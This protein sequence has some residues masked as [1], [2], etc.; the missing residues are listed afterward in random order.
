[1]KVTSVPVATDLVSGFEVIPGGPTV[2]KKRKFVNCTVLLCFCMFL[3][4]ERPLE[5]KLHCM[6]VSVQV[7]SDCEETIRHYTA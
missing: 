2:R 4:V 1:M 7:G 6:H 3:M 5:V